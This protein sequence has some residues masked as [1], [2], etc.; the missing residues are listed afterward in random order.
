MKQRQKW[1]LLF[2]IAQQ[3][4][5]KSIASK[6]QNP[7]HSSPKDIMKSFVQLHWNFSSH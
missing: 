3:L 4:D 7:I 6:D 5:R 2:E 1:L